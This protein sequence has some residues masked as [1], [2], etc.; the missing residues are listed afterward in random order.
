MNKI[1]R[2]LTDSKASEPAQGSAFH[3]DAEAIAVKQFSVE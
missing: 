1:L 3:G 2:R